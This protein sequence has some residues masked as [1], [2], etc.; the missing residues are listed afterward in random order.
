VVGWQ[1]TTIIQVMRIEVGSRRG[2]D[3]GR[4]KRI[5]DIVAR[6]KDTVGGMFGPDASHLETLDS[7][8]GPATYNSPPEI[9]SGDI[10][11]DYPGGWET[12]CAP[13]VV[14]SEPFPLTL[15]S[16]QTDVE[17]ER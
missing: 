14:Q 8:T 16:I 1:Y 9:F 15:V 7:T 13:M 6:L 17:V 4:I 5:N 12:D 10:T 11:Q 3:Q 2:V